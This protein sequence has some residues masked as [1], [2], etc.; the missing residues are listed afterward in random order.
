MTKLIT[1]AVVAA[2]VLSVPVFA[3]ENLQ[4][5]GSGEFRGIYLFQDSSPD[6]QFAQSEIYLWA[7][8][9]LADNVMVKIN[10]KYQNNFGTTPSGIGTGDVTGGNVR[11]QEAYLKLGKIWDSQISAVVGRWVAE[12]SS[13][14][15][16]LAQNRSSLVPVYGEGFMIPNNIAY[17]GIRVTWDSDPTWIDALWYKNSE[18]VTSANDDN[19]LY[20]IYASTKAFENWIFDGYFLYNDNQNGVP[21]GTIET[22]ILGGRAEGKITAVEGLSYKGELA[23]TH[24]HVTGPGDEPDGFGGYAGINYDFAN[25]ENNPSARLNFYYLEQN[26]IQPYGH[27][28]QDDLG[29]SGYGRIVDFDSNLTNG[30]YFF[31]VGG[32]IKPAEKWSVDA[33]YYH[34]NTIPGNSVF[35][36]ELDLRLSY[37]YSEN[38]AAEVIGGYYVSPGTPTGLAKAISL[39]LPDDA[40][41]IKGGIKVSF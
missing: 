41:L 38:V 17:D 9:D 14:G 12:K 13:E 36:H 5:G 16:T 25:M 34:Y 31:N 39:G 1:L 4:F 27:V 6:T 15:I 8:A 23:Y 26:F 7:S 10:L 21:G 28:D 30:G 35:G 11:M 20:G 22:L 29:E 33:D 37:Q 32:T 2:L 40:Y 18:G 19:T 3:A 24:A